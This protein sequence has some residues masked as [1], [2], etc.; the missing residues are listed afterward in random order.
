MAQLPPDIL[1][2]IG[3]GFCRKLTSVKRPSTTTP[4]TGIGSNLKAFFRI[5]VDHIES[6]LDSEKAWR[7]YLEVLSP[8]P[9]QRW[10][11]TRLNVELKEA[12][13]RLDDVGSMEDLQQETM[14]QWKWDNRI[15]DVAQHLIATCFYFEKTRIEVALEDDSYV[16]S[17]RSTT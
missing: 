8:G 10:R 6:S 7:D 2:S 5:A 9:E 3:S 11:Y 14:R 1:L 15:T 12:P 16:C 17:G 4:R 13:P